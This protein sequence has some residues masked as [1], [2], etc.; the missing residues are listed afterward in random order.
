MVFN[1][2][3]Y[4]ALLD[5]AVPSQECSI[6]IKGVDCLARTEPM[7][8][9]TLVVRLDR[10]YARYS[11]QRRR[12]GVSVKVWKG[13]GTRRLARQ[14]NTRSRTGTVLKS[15]TCLWQ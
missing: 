9:S 2:G 1:T 5:F 7:K 11:F 3:K 6:P 10:T 8:M 14:W 4:D 13:M 15:G 12:C